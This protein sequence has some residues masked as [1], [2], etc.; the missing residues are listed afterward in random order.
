MPETSALPR[1]RPASASSRSRMCVTSARQLLVQKAHDTQPKATALSSAHVP[2]PDHARP[3]SSRPPAPVPHL[4]LKAQHSFQKGPSTSHAAFPAPSAPRDVRGKASHSSR[5]AEPQLRACG[6][7]EFLTKPCASLHAAG[8]TR[9]PLEGLSRKAAPLTGGTTSLGSPRYR[10]DSP[11]NLQTLQRLNSPRDRPPR[12]SPRD[13]RLNSPR[14]RDLQRLNSPR[15]KTSSGLANGG[16]RPNPSNGGPGVPSTAVKSATPRIC[17]PSSEATPR[18]CPQSPAAGSGKLSPATTPR[19]SGSSS[20]KEGLQTGSAGPLPSADLAATACPAAP[21]S[22]VAKEVSGRVTPR[23][24]PLASFSSK[25][26]SETSGLGSKRTSGSSMYEV[27]HGSIMQMPS[28]QNSE[29]CGH[30]LAHG[31]RH[32]PPGVAASADVLRQTQ[33]VNEVHPNGSPESCDV[34]AV[35]ARSYSATA[36]TQHRQELQTVHASRSSVSVERQRSYSATNPAVSGAPSRSYLMRVRFELQSCHTALHH[37]HDIMETT[38]QLC[39]PAVLGC[40]D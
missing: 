25:R 19:L 37:V 28:K 5:S 20:N 17:N 21:P 7:K 27:S 12:H 9:L 10:P 2:E 40:S 3:K 13:C 33:S 35:G 1:A 15:Q 38:R 32:S 22:G 8:V 36:L 4:N 14:N 23:P 24:S 30:E 6:P 16:A 39:T 26:G 29:V 11:R 18:P 31:A 34:A